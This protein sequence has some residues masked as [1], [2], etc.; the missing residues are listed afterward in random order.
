LLYSEDVMLTSL[1]TLPNQLLL[2]NQLS[3]VHN[4]HIIG[5]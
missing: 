3:L 5:I 4:E 2:N 1:V